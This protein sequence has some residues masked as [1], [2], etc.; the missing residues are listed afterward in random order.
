MAKEKRNYFTLLKSIAF[1]DITPLRR[2]SK[3]HII[4]KFVLILNVRNIYLLQIGNYIGCYRYT[5]DMYTE[6]HT[7]TELSLIIFRPENY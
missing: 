5:A 4:I 2:L 7:V 3:T 6:N 1:S